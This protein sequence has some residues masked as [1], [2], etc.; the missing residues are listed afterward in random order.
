MV[1]TRFL[2]TFNGLIIVFGSANYM[3]KKREK[4]KIDE[5][6]GNERRVY[7]ICFDLYVMCVT[8]FGKLLF[9]SVRLCKMLFIISLDG[10]LN[11]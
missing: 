5:K 4:K 10:Q 7:L 9:R 3:M 2:M 11:N 6:D 8:S 1:F